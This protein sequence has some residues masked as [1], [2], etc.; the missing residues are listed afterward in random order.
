[1]RP[2]SKTRTDIR[3]IEAWQNGSSGEDV[4]VAVIDSL[5]RWDHPDLKEREFDSQ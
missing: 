2:D 4:V 5:I 3:A 1:M